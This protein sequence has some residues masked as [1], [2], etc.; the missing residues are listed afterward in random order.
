MFFWHSGKYYGG[1]GEAWAKPSGSHNLS[2][3]LVKLELCKMLF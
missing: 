1:L 2:F 3:S